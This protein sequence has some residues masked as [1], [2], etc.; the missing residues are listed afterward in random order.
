MH[1]LK[2]EL[3]ELIKNDENIFDFLLNSALDG[4]W[5]WDLENPARQY[6]DAKFFKLLGLNPNDDYDTHSNW[7]DYVLPEDIAMAKAH[8]SAHVHNS[9]YSIDFNLRYKHKTGRI[10]WVKIRGLAILNSNGKPYRFLGAQA[11]ITKQKEAEIELVKQNVKYNNIILGT[12]LGTWEWNVQTGATV[13]N[14]RWAQIIGYSLEELGEISIETWTKYAHPDDL[15]Q[16]GEALEKHFSGETEFYECESRMKHKDGHWVWVLDKGQVIS[17]T[18]DGKPLIMMGSHQDITER[19]TNE[20]QLA[21]YKELLEKVNDAARIGTW[22]VSLPAE[23]ATWSKVTYEIHEVPF[24]TKVP[25]S[26]AINF[27]KPGYSRDTI[28]EKFQRSM[29]FGEPYDVELELITATGKEKWV[30]AIGFPVFED[31]KCVKTY[32]I[33]QDIH[34]SKAAKLLLEES[35]RKFRLTFENAPVGIAIVGLDRAFVDVNNS[36]CSIL[37]YTK[38]ELLALSIKDVSYQ[39]DYE[40][41]NSYFEQ[42][43]NGDFKPFKTEK[44]YLNK[45]GEIIWAD[46]IVIPILDDNNELIQLVA[47]IRDITEQKLSKILIARNER[48]FK[49]I[50]DNS[51]SHILLLNREGQIIEANKPFLNFSKTKKSEVQGRTLGELG[52]LEFVKPEG[53]EFSLEELVAKAAMGVHQNGEFYVKFQNVELPVVV[54]LTAIENSSNEIEFIVLECRPVADLVEAKN[55]LANNLAHINALL[56]A[57]TDVAIIETDTA[58]LFKTFNKGAENLLGYTADE[59]INKFSPVDVVLESEVIERMQPIIELNLSPAD[60]YKMIVDTHYEKP[61]Q[62]EE[63]TYVR[64]DKTTFPGFMVRTPILDKNGVIVGLLGVISDYTPIK[65][66][67]NK[68]KSLIEVADDQNNRL[69][70]FSH[71]IAHNL[72]STMS[73]FKMLLQL[74]ELDVPEATQNLYYPK[75]QETTNSLEETLT[76]LNEV[77]DINS[78]TLDQ[79]ESTNLLEFTNKV[80][81]SL[82]YLITQEHVD[83]QVEIPEAFQVQAIPA[84]LESILYNLINNA[85]KYHSPD[86][87]IQV[88]I[89]AELIGD[90]IQLC[91]EDNGLGINLERFGDKLFGMYKTFHGNKDAKGL[92]LFITK[93]QVEAMGGK[94]GVESSVNEGSTFKV[95]LKTS[96]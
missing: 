64:K 21:H 26:E 84:Y 42:Y 35:E 30:R 66:A 31:G 92:G 44:R 93:N 10:I 55:E 59:V 3:Y 37:G 91:V 14:E 46:L 57:S 47:Q 54:G 4:I 85:V 77:V 9:K 1:L 94:I 58:G 56:N 87:A 33:F 48:K 43:F 7:Y 40:L 80:C 27:Y 74:M 78:K 82:D 50:F 41:T 75:L 2:K 20:L 22:E 25:I 17:Y 72:R 24:K 38:K 61:V 88:R 79:L 73:N 29:E 76:H 71:I 23:Y 63:W 60:S 89:R 70:N 81:K 53:Q 83:L 12:E 86:R 67:E 39:D 15:K 51:Y 69:M 19:K 90:F 95:H 34:E 96:A 68:L 16:S 13:F 18:S 28:L 11:E 36:L 8:I 5:F 6:M 52:F 62:T 65:T 32:G 49:S 45:N